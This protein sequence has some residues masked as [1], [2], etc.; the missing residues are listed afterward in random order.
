MSDDLIKDV[1]DYLSTNIDTKLLCRDVSRAKRYSVGQ[2]VMV[3]MSGGAS[4]PLVLDSTDFPHVDITVSMGISERA[5]SESARMAM[6]IYRLTECDC[7]VTINDTFYPGI[8]NVT[9]PMASL[10]GDRTEYRWTVEVVR[11]YGLD[12]VSQEE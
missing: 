8:H 1:M 7:G 6:A 10:N 9:S 3:S 12:Q 5:D 4:A 11:Y 2:Y